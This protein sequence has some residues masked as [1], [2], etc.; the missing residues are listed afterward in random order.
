[1]TVTVRELLDSRPVENIGGKNSAVRFFSVERDSPTLTTPDEVALLFGSNDLPQKGEAFPGTT[2]EAVDYR[3]RKF[4][5]QTDLFHVTWV[6]RDATTGGVG[7]DLQPN[8]VGYVEVSGNVEAHFE[9]AW[10]SLSSA[11]MTQLVASGGM[12]PYGN[13]TVFSD[14]GGSHV[15]AAGEPVSVMR[16]RMNVTVSVTT[17][18]KPTQFG[19]WGQFVGRRNNT[20]FGGAPIGSLVY[21]GAGFRRFD[22]GRWTVDHSFVLDSWYHMAQVAWRNMRGD[23]GLGGDGKAEWVWFVQPFPD[24]GNFYAIDPYFAGQV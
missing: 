4:E 14:I 15:D 23:V 5:G 17:A 22:D 1:M 18:T 2:L 11:E 24:F 16:R 20:E 13:N 7:I 9:D 8:E 21:T 10:R 3:I 19:L 12:Y 6:Y